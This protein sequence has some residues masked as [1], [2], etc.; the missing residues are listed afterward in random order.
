MA[1]NLLTFA[2]IK[3]STK[4]KLRDG[5]GLWLHT[6]KAGHRYWVF[7]YIRQGRRREMGLGPYG[8]GTGQ[9]SLAAARAK[10]DAIRAILGEGRD[11]FTE[12]PERRVVVKPKT[13][14]EVADA[15]IDACVDGGKWR[16]AK[17]EA[18]WRNTLTNHAKPLRK[19]LVSE[20]TTEDVL[21]V[22]KPIWH[23]KHETA[24]KLR[25]RI[26]MVL[27]SA[28]VQG[29][30]AGDNPAKWT[31]HL[32]QVLTLPD[33][34]KRGHHAAMPYKD[35]PAF[36]VKLREVEGMGARALE[37]TV[38]T[39]A[40]SGETRG[41]TWDEIDL[42]EKLWT[43][44]PHRMK[45]GRPHRVPLC[46]R[47][48]DLLKEVKAKRLSDLVFP[49]MKP[50]SPLSDMTLSKALKTADGNGYTVH[51][52]RS[53]LRDWVHEETDYQTEIAEAALAHATG[54]AVER[55]YR[56]GDALEKRRALL[57]DWATY[58]ASGKQALGQRQHS[59]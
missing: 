34:M 38:L 39:A 6:S 55:A 57:S 23:E 26:K 7:I 18:G 52:F 37:F 27:D 16:G 49:G 33:E 14:G 22:L 3:A 50:K 42:E 24:T 29:F 21:R 43:I 59:G 41:A 58:C 40:R 25:E 20:I 4:A 2:K 35:I 9:V 1:R 45:S 56:R 51:G 13:F 15:Y 17:T 36:M 32:Q 19:I 53:S 31:G 8:S 30:R 12:L 54:S 47:A 44:P 28:K 48:I 10:A 46:N 5:D 11:P